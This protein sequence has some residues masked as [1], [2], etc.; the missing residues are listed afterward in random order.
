MRQPIADPSL[1]ISCRRVTSIVGRAGAGACEVPGPNGFGLNLA[2]S[3]Y[4]PRPDAS[5][6]AGATF[7][8]LGLLG[9]VV[10]VAMVTALVAC[11]P[12][13][14][15]SPTPTERFR[16]DEAAYAA[17]EE[18]Y[19]GYAAAT[20]QLDLSDP[21]SFETV[22]AWLAGSALASEREILSAYNAE[23]LTKI[24]TTTFDQ[25]TPVSVT[26]SVVVVDLCLDIS[27]IELLD[28]AGRSVVSND[29]P[30]RVAR[31]VTFVEGESTTGLL[32]KSH[33]IIDDKLEC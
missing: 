10:G 22:F 24:G 23:S 9:A 31:R 15:A 32:V 4:R 8:L 16:T 5:V 25:F 20:N 14:A 26:G 2:E 11:A 28:S 12:K 13:P 30:S 18:T 19:R 29:R 33:Q 6:G 7:S 3:R 21:E 17:A 1:T 27:D